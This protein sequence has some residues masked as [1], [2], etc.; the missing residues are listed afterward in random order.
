MFV[1]KKKT[2]Q[3]SNILNIFQKKEMYKENNIHLNEKEGNLIDGEINEDDVVI[4]Y[5]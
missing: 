2:Q 4:K 5:C 1:K 3:H